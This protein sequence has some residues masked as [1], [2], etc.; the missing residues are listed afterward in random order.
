MTLGQRVA[1]MEGGDLQQV[2]PPMEL[3][4]RPANVFVAG[5][6]G[7]PAMNFFRAEL[8]GRDGG[9]IV[10]GGFFEVE[11]AAAGD[12]GR[13]GGSDTDGGNDRD[14]DVDADGPSD[15]GSRSCP[16]VLGIRPQDLS[17]TSPGDDGDFETVVEVVEPLGNELLVH[18]RRPAGANWQGKPEGVSSREPMN[19]GDDD[20]IRALVPA[21]RS[22]EVDEGVGV[23]FRRDRIHLFDA[24]SGNRLR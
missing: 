4:H 19:E 22:V 17:V 15:P 9:G 6:V 13:F 23:R 18:L 3:F 21:E 20:E 14:G 2:A 10:R 11:P 24:E 8:Q 12:E 5:F 7:S 16:V 1:V